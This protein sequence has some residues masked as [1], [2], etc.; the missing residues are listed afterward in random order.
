MNQSFHPDK[1][2][3]LLNRSA[4]QLRPDTLS[5]LRDARREALSHHQLRYA[6]APALSAASLG[7]RLRPLGQH[8]LPY[9]LAALVLLTTLC[10]GGAAY[11][12]HTSEPSE[13]ID[14]AILTDDLP[15]Q[16]YVD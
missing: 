16:V 11:W 8:R 10:V 7:S 2:R 3:Q 4:T 6:G 14:I 9:Y 15:I 12:Q 5:A 1:I 13:E